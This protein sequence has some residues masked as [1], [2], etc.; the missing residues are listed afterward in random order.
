M[1]ATYK[2]RAREVDLLLIQPPVMK[3]ILEENRTIAR[4]FDALDATGAL[5][6]D[7]PTEPNLGLLSIAANV[8]KNSPELRIAV[9]DLNVA[10]RQ[11][12][13]ESCTPIGSEDIRRLLR[14]YD[15]AV[16]GIS[17][18]TTAY[19]IWGKRLC[20]VCRNEFE[21][22]YVVLGGIHPTARF[23]EVMQECGESIDAI[24][25]GEGEKVIV[26][27]LEILGTDPRCALRHP[28][29]FCAG[30]R[31]REVTRAHLSNLD[32]AQLPP[33]A[34]D[35]LPPEAMPV[36]VRFYT[37][38]GCSNSC[39]FCSVGEFFRGKLTSAVSVGV[40]SVM[41]SISQTLREV[42]VSHVVIGNLSM[43]NSALADRAFAR[44]LGDLL[45]K[46][47]GVSGWWCQTRGD[48]LD[49]ETI[50]LLAESKCLQVAIGCEGGTDE[51]LR[52]IRKR[53]TTDSIRRTLSNLREADIE[54][55]CYWIIGLP[56]DS[57]TDASATQSKIL[58]YL[59][60]DLT[61]LTHIT[62]LVPYPN[63]PAARQPARHNIRIHHE[64][65]DQYWMNCDRFGCG[66]PVYDTL[67]RNG[68]LA[69]TSSDIYKM[70]LETLGLVTEF[71][72]SRRA[73]EDA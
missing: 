42:D 3:P 8:R 57:V 49:Q 4:Y 69:M 6:G 45:N 32:L 22:A 40:A 5:L 62:I 20:E 27:L 43:F 21:D 65:W 68:K 29:I 39:S 41:T 72:D 46:E 60:D 25:L 47:I 34:F 55:E 37:E 28:N 50:R 67:D 14:Q 11:I 16:I 58:E 15:P 56:G 2:D 44:E 36:A 18:M 7:T 73:K 13:S 35:L 70:W 53:E 26:E 33:P 24:I 54:T 19:G 30:N 64:Q 59:H 12:R 9:L 71:Y 10:E 31:P 63:T 38:R 61:T 52:R 1:P 51:Q 23:E 66:F 17:F 48:L